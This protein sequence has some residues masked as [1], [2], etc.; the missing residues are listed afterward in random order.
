MFVEILRQH[1]RRFLI[2]LLGAQS[3]K[4]TKTL[5]LGQ[6]SRIS[7]LVSLTPKWPRTMP[8]ASS[9]TPSVRVE[10]QAVDKLLLLLVMWPAFEAVVIGRQY[11]R[12]VP[13]LLSSGRRLSRSHNWPHAR[14]ARAVSPAT[15]S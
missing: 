2:W 9:M 7:F 1:F 15:V 12:T 10:F 13:G 8:T 6:S 4:F 11:H 5:R 14:L 3:G